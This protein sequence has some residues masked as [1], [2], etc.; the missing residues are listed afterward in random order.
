[1]SEQGVNNTHLMLGLSVV[2]YVGPSFISPTFLPSLPPSVSPFS[3]PSSPH[4]QGFQG[5][6]QITREPHGTEC[7]LLYVVLGGQ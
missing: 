1:M 2:S 3:F 7:P 4:L 6:K 5:F